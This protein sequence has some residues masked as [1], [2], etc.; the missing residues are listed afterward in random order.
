[1]I[2]LVNQT[3]ALNHKLDFAKLWVS[4][5]LPEKYKRFKVRFLGWLKNKNLK[6]FGPEE[7][8]RIVGHKNV[9]FL[10]GN[11]ETRS[12]KLADKAKCWVVF[13]S[14]YIYLTACNKIVRTFVKVGK[15]RLFS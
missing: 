12:S 13:E 2:W 7:S 6:V 8:R 5:G 11:Y 4:S 10:N 1:M 3:I 14:S 9:Y 15:T